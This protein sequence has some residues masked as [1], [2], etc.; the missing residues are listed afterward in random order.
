VGG[1]IV[2]KIKMVA[3][4]VMGLM[5]TVLL[6]GCGGQPATSKVLKVGMDAAFAPFE[7]QDDKSNEYAGFDVD[8]MKAIG[9]QMGVE[10]EFQ[11]IG[12]DGLIPALDSNNIDVIASGMTIQEDRKAKVTFSQPYFKSGLSILVKN[13]NT[14]IQSFKDLEGKK[15]AVQIGS[16]SAEAA[17][18]IPNA[19][20]RE[21]NTPPDAFMELTSG[22]VEAVIND[23]P[24][25]QD[26]INH[27]TN[28]EVKIVGDLLQAEDYGLAVAKK[29]TELAKKID[30]ALTVIKQNGEYDKIYQ[31]W[32]G[33]K[34]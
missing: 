3:G 31:K 25:N 33:V 10:V 11:N 23:L 7:F 15:I 14:T 34:K 18:K 4:L 24:V 12:F 5:L 26:Y 16:T 32:F 22:G 19:Q 30:D 9:K 20:V 1:F 2:S 27:S 8:L 17:K 6:G 13:D 21:F 28:K 29:N